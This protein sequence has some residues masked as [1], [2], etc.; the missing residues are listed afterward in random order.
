MVPVEF[1]TKVIPSRL[2]YVHNKDFELDAPPILWHYEGAFGLT[3]SVSST[4]Y[5][6]RFPIH[7][8]QA[9]SS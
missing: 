3:V 6:V 2:V 9:V 8:T 5:E 7:V 1:E 4:N